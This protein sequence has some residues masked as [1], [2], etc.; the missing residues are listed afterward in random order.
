MTN[1]NEH[2]TNPEPSEPR[3]PDGTE[4][5]RCSCG[6]DVSPEGVARGSC[7]VCGRFL[8]GNDAAVIH[9]GRAQLTAADYSARDA[10]MNRLLAER[11]GRGVLDIVAQLRIEDYATAQIQLGKVTKR[12]EQLG[13]VSTAGNKRSSLVDTYNTFS[14]RVER[15]AAELPPVVNAAPVVTTDLDTLTDD[16]LIEK[17]TTILRH[18]L[19][20]QAARREGEQ[21]RTARE[22]ADVDK[23]PLQAGGFNADA[24]A[25]PPPAPVCEFCGQ[26]PCVG[27]EHHAY[28][29]LHARDP[30]VIARRDREATAEMHASLR[31][32]GVWRG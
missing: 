4:T 23:G 31:R 10:L 8:P 24:P 3:T 6:A 29:V 18:L 25:E 13:A 30:E 19:D 12:L 28:D 14:A 15:L 16:Q 11:G 1:F 27:P 2:L 32:Y 5:V 9:A 7:N 26:R 21:L 20:L 17:T 22:R